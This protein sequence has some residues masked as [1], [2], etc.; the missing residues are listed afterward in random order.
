VIPPGVWLLIAV[1][2]GLG[3]IA[4]ALWRIGSAQRAVAA[5]Q[6]DANLHARF[7]DQRDRLRTLDDVEALAAQLAALALA[8]PIALRRGLLHI[9]AQP[10][11]YFTITDLD[12]VRYFFTTD[13][14]ALRRARVVRRSDPAR[15]LSAVSIAARADVA[16][17]WRTL[18]GWHGLAH[19]A[20]PRGARWHVVAFNPIRPRTALHRL[21]LTRLR[22]RRIAQSE[23][24]GVVSADAPDAPSA[25]PV[26]QPMPML[27]APQLAGGEL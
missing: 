5:L 2:L 13:L 23:G 10:A 20:L 25:A 11:P 6:A 15:N 1:A 16:A 8:R 18:T 4:I 24:L 17:V 26:A 21:L 12:G 7:V 19:I 22:A 3:A 9:G 14:N 27:G